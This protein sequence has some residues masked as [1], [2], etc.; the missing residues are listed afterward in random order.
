[1]SI[2]HVRNVWRKICAKVYDPSEAEFVM[3]DVAFT[4]CILEMHFPPSFFDVMTHLLVHVVEE[5]DI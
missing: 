4:L 2:Y 5:L 1:M 3:K